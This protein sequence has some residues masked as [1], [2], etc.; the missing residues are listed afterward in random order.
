[1][2]S[3]K[4]TAEHLTGIAGRIAVAPVPAK[5]LTTADAV[6]QLLPTLRKMLSAGHTPDSIAPLLQ[7]EGLQVSA[8]ALA[9]LMRN[10]KSSRRASRVTK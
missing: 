7:A 6:R 8:R 2:S 5:P 1:M 4:L 3:Q 10:G 9:R